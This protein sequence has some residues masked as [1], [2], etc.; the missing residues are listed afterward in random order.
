MRLAR[1]RIQRVA[2]SA[3]VRIE[4]FL[5]NILAHRFRSTS[6]T[7]RFINV[8]PHMPIVRFGSVQCQPSLVCLSPLLFDPTYAHHTYHPHNPPGRRNITVFSKGKLRTWDRHWRSSQSRRRFSN[9]CCALSIPSGSA[10]IARPSQRQSTSQGPFTQF[11]D[12]ESNCNI[13][14]QIPYSLSS[15]ITRSNR[16]RS[17]ACASTQARKRSFICCKIGPIATVGRPERRESCVYSTPEGRHGRERW[18]K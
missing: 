16:C 8:H 14:Y 9:S 6:S 15:H 13:L 18:G 7:P 11:E 4:I 10:I 5:F 2:V 1:K 17:W 3:K 12:E